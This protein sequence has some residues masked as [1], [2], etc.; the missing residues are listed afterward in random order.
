MYGYQSIR[1]AFGMQC[2]LLPPPCY[3]NSEFCFQWGFNSQWDDKWSSTLGWRA[4]DCDRKKPLRGCQRGAR[5]HPMY[6]VLTQRFL[7]AACSMVIWRST[8]LLMLL[9]GPFEVA[10]SRLSIFHP[11]FSSY[12]PLLNKRHVS[13]IKQDS[14]F[15]WCFLLHPGWSLERL[16]CLLLHPGFRLVAAYCK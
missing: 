15:A 7:P 8:L 9:E 2:I 5:N 10:T 11:K 13:T 1:V 4:S 12:S 14:I 16:M 6:Q 3:I